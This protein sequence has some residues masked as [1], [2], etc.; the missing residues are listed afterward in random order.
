MA[1]YGL[2]LAHVELLV[3]ISI[4]RRKKIVFIFTIK[5]LFYV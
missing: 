5:Y 4:L 1:V 3:S 2:K